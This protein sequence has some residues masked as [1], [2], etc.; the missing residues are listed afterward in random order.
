[1]PGEFPCAFLGGGAEAGTVGGVVEKQRC[2]ADQLGFIRHEDAGVVVDNRILQAGGTAV[3]HRRDGVLSGLNHR[4]TPAFLAGGHHVQG[5][6]GEQGVL[7]AL[8]H[9]A[10]KLHT[11]THPKLGRIVPQL[12]IPPA[13]ADHIQHH[14]MRGRHRRQHV[15][16]M[17]DLLVRNQPGQR[18]Q[19][20][21]SIVVPEQRVLRG[22]IGQ[23]VHSV[24]DNLN[25]IR[26]HTQLHQ[27]GSTGQ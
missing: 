16:R 18:D 1:M 12:R 25:A 13:A 4:Q 21:P 6:A 7:H 15:H 26:V 23:R 14:I 10:V 27:L 11:I 24:A 2:G 9:L 3:P 19:M 5:C 22:G 20:H 17:F 8:R